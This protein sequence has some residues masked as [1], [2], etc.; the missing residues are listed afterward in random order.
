MTALNSNQL[1]WL[2]RYAG[3]VDSRARIAA[4]IALAES[5]GNSDAHNGNAATG[6]DSYGLWQINMIGAMGPA[7][8]VE[9]GIASNDALLNPATNA[10]AMARMSGGGLNFTPWTTYTR[11]T[12]LQYLGSINTSGDMKTALKSILAAQTGLVATPSGLAIPGIPAGQNPLGGLS[13]VTNLVTKTG[14]AL[15]WLSTPANWWRIAG[16]TAGAI[17]III[18]LVNLLQPALKAGASVAAPIVKAVA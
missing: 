6:D 17:L 4:A 9:F 18:S 8:R 2:A 12:Y 1:Y 16:I 15:T 13:G 5:G 3:L 10:R 11:G 7:R 14:K